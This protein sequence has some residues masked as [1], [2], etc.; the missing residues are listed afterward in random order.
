MGSFGYIVSQIFGREIEA[1]IFVVIAMASAAA[2]I[3]VALIW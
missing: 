1:S 3:A 2:I